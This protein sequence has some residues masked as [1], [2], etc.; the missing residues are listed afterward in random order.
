MTQLWQDAWRDINLSWE[1]GGFIAEDQE[2][3]CGCI[4]V[5]WCFCACFQLSNLFMPYLIQDADFFGN[6]NISIGVEGSNGMASN[7]LGTVDYYWHGSDSLQT[8][9]RLVRRWNFL[10]GLTTI[11]HEVVVKFLYFSPLIRLWAPPCNLTMTSPLL[12]TQIPC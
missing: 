3:I 11:I 12:P 7:T 2:F 1:P 4:K 5:I 9:G 10:L 8:W 6:A